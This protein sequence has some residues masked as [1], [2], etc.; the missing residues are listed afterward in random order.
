MVK[1]NSSVNKYNQRQNGYNIE[2]AAAKFLKQ[3]HG[4]KWIDNNFSCKLGE[5][6]LIM[7]NQSH[8]IFVEVRFRSSPHFA[9]G[10]SSITY[11]KQQKLKKTALYYLQQHQLMDKVN[12]RFDV[13]SAYPQYGQWHFEWIQ[14]AFD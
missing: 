9:D 3:K 13:V 5:I 4:L 1:L 11:Q 10:A 2:Q 6:D 7:Q 8:L 14:N 12:A